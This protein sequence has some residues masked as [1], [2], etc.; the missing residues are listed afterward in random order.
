MET[1]SI[2]DKSTNQSWQMSQAFCFSSPHWPRWKRSLT[3]DFSTPNASSMRTPSFVVLIALSR[4]AKLP[5][6]SWLFKLASSLATL[7]Y[8]WQRK[9]ILGHCAQRMTASGRPRGGA[10]RGDSKLRLGPTECF[11]E[12]SWVIRRS[13]QEM[14]PK[15]PNL[16]YRTRS[17]GP[18][19]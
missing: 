7:S 18:A 14:S 16:I 19:K 11:D 3:A 5:Y 2:P 9:L 6:G 8:S 4:P 15:H 13:P 10:I 12:T 1:S 17:T